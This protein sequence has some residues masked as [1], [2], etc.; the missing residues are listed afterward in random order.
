MKAKGW[1]VQVIDPKFSNTG[2]QTIRFAY[3]LRI[4]RIGTSDA[5]MGLNFDNLTTYS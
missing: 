3:T 1:D 2:Q 4:N 5:V